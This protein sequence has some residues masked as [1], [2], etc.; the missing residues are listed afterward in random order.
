MHITTL[1]PDLRKN[2][3]N[4]LQGYVE[5]CE[6]SDHLTG[7]IEFPIYFMGFKY[8]APVFTHIRPGQP[9]G[10]RPVLGLIGWNTPNSQLASQILLQFI[11]IL[12][13]HPRLFGTSVLRLL[14]V[15]NPVA[16]EL[17]EDAP[18]RED[19]DL[20]RALGDR[21]TEQATDG[22]IEVE[23]SGVK[24]FTLVGEINPALQRILENL[25]EIIPAIRGRIAV[26]KVFDVKPTG[27]DERWNLRLLVPSD[28]SDPRSVHAVAGFIVRLLHAEARVARRL[29]KTTRGGA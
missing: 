2:L 26:P 9:W 21:F 1:H 6:F 5:H 13:Q 7:R 28:W 19:W 23:S 20:L 25:G 16:L 14:P 3:R 11:E 29:R 4:L 24:D 27:P 17:D 15:A 10:D 8:G 22:L 18:D 12:T